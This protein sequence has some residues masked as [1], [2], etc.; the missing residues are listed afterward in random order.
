M[1]PTQ[2][3]RQQYTLRRRSLSTWKPPS[4]NGEPPAM[5]TSGAEAPSGAMSVIVMLAVCS[6]PQP[7]AYTTNLLSMEA[8]DC[9][10]F[11]SSQL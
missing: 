7:G 4:Q 2:T 5:R 6:L 11:V 8:C 1:P 9:S 10:R 3:G